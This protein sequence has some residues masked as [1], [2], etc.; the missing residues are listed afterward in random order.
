MKTAIEYFDFNSG[1]ISD[2]GDPLEIELSSRHLG[3]KGVLLEKGWSPYFYPNN[4]YTNSFYFA[5]A[6]DSPLH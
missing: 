5:L 6:L 1:K 3:W 2:C 4:I